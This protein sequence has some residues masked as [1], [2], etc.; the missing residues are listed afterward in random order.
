M[1]SVIMPVYNE[2]KYLRKAID[3]VLNQTYADFE[4]IIINDG[5]I[6][7]TYNIILELQKNDCRIKLLNHEKNMGLIKSLNDGLEVAKGDIIARMDGDD[8][9][10]GT[11]FQ[12]QIDFLT[13]NSSVKLVGS[14]VDIIDSEDKVIGEELFFT[15]GKDILNFSTRM[16]IDIQHP[17]IMA[18]REAFENFKY[19]DGYKHAEDYELFCRMAEQFEM[20]NI[21]EKLLMYRRHESS[22]SNQNRQQQRL[23]AT[24]IAEEAALRRNINTN[25][26]AMRYSS[27]WHNKCFYAN[28]EEM[29]KNKKIIFVADIHYYDWIDRILFPIKGCKCA[30]KFDVNE[31]SMAIKELSEKRCDYI[32]VASRN[33]KYVVDE[34]KM[35]GLTEDLIIYAFFCRKADIA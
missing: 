16:R 15:N 21:P 10:C 31:I 1:I 6:D 7:D 12:K 19:R 9:C 35:T 32:C 23:M 30:A 13:R 22:V 17:T 2:Q 26:V 4:L 20:A 24:R 28:Y 27:D 34:M 33:W 18:R 5:S 29:L 25:T 8:I 11:R 14:Y 3:S